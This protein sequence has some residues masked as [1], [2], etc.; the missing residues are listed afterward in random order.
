DAMTITIAPAATANAGVDFEVCSTAP[1]AH[2]SGSVG[3]GATTGTWSGGAGSFNPN[4]T[5]LN[6][7]YTP[8]AGEIAAGRVALP[9]TTTDPA[10]RCGAVSS[11]VRVTIGPAASVNAGLDQ[12]VCS[13][14][15]QV[16]LAGSV[17]G[18]ATSGSWSGGAGSFSPNA[19][20]LNAVY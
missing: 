17:G 18:G 14:S 15:P 4:A 5:N 9:L 16:V 12:T 8:S 2:L 13:A 19:S 11:E 1:Q 6:A 3:G 20:V 10:G 7:V